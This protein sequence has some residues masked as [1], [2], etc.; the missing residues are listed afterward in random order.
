MPDLRALLL[1]VPIALLYL[2]GCSTGTPR[3]P[4]PVFGED[5]TSFRDELA[6]ARTLMSQGDIATAEPIVR[7]ILAG[8]T[9]P[10]M[11]RQRALAMGYLGNI[12]QRHNQLDSAANCH[13]AVIAMAQE[14]GQPETE[15]T[16]RI[17]LGVALEMKGDHAGALGQQLEAFRLKEHLADS[18]G[19][20]RGL[21]N[22]GML[23]ARTGDT[24]EARDLFLR[25][26][27]LNERVARAGGQTGDSASWHRSLMNLA[28]VEMDLGRYDTALVLLQRSAEV[29]PPWMFNGNKAALLTNMALAHEGSGHWDTA[30][31]LYEEAL[32]LARQLDDQ[33]SLGELRHFLADLL[34]RTGKPAQALAHLDTALTITRELGDRLSE[35]NILLSQAQAYAAT[36]RHKEAYAAQL[37]Y[38]ALADSL[39]NAGKDA[40][41]RELHVKYDVERKENENQRLR[42][43]AE[44]AEARGQNLRWM[45]AAALVLAAGTGLVARL[46]AQRS[47]ERAQ[48]R[49][50]NLEQ[51][52]LRAQMDPHFL[53]N[54]LNTIPGL[55]ANADVRTATAYVGHLSNLLRLIL[56]SSRQLMVPLR[57]ELQL[58]EHYLHVSA[59]R[60]PGMFHHEII[61]G[62]DIDTDSVAIPPMLLQPLV[63]NAILHGLV[64]RRS[65]GLLRITIHRDGGMLIC[66]IRDNGVGRAASALN[67]GRSLTPS[68]GLQIT[69]ERLRQFNR[70]AGMPH[71]LELADLHNSEGRP[72]GTE[73][74]VRTIFRHTWT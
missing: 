68:R 65:D 62:G 66:R 14:H 23:H 28:V 7:A 64:P 2:G 58:I 46:L 57:Q 19:M 39:M 6:A 54:A 43:A 10:A 26:V 67:G 41:M 70:G 20:A 53:F 36:G 47:R 12:M 60:H 24:L 40:V 35:R 74:V 27:A 59:S 49:E 8:A 48:R 38:T 52:A 71:G 15:A 1:L 11:V 13:L 72:T 17:N 34:V 21:N 3:M 22:I 31:A 69:I 37:G 42:T 56:E 50:A 30:R 73:A 29:C 16:A 45:L 5:S 55:Y 33:W 18:A 63:E 44:L 9:A 25:S 61:V 32:E 4:A 51:Q